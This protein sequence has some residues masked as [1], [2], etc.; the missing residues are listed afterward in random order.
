MLVRPGP[1]PD[2]MVVRNLLRSEPYPS[3][4]IKVSWNG[5]LFE[6]IIITQISEAMRSQRSRLGPKT[7]PSDRSDALANS[8]EEPA[9]VLLVGKQSEEALRALR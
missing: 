4:S 2:P 6:V 5:S 9:Q 7:R 3:G 1:G 8:V